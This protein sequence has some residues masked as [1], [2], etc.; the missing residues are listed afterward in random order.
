MANVGDGA[1]VE[2]CFGAGRGI[3]AELA[4]G[5]EEGSAGLISF[6]QTGETGLSG[7]R[8]TGSGEASYPGEGSAAHSGRVSHGGLLEVVPLFISGLGGFLLDS[9]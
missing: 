7:R 6:P 3:L 4:W 9:H 2:Y 1:F 5:N 8:D